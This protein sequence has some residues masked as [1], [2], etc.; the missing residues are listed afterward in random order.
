MRGITL[1]RTSRRGNNRFIAMPLCR[2]I[3]RLKVVATSAISSL[4]TLFD[5]SGCLCLSPRAHVVTESGNN[6]LRYQYFTA[7]GAL[8]ALRQTCFCTVRTYTFIGYLAMSCRIF[9]C[10]YKI[11]TAAI[12]YF[13][14]AFSASVFPVL[15]AD[16]YA[17]IVCMVFY[18]T[19]III[20]YYI[21]R[22][23]IDFFF[24]PLLTCTLKVYCFYII[25]TVE[26]FRTLC[27]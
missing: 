23:S 17:I 26:N 22:Y 11:I 24:C 9:I 6:I 1:F 18:R 27:F 20:N 25:A 13:F 3:T 16:E 7:L 5:T 14:P 21:F 2:D 10:A 8:F 4:T 12:I 15:A 19:V